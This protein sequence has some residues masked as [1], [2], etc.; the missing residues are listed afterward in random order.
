M[1]NE[2]IERLNEEAAALRVRRDVEYAEY[3]QAGRVKGHVPRE[4]I[5]KLN[6][7]RVSKEIRNKFLSIPDMTSTVSDVLDSFGVDTAIPAYR[8]TAVISGSKICGS[9]FTIR[10]L[11]TQKT[12][13]QYAQEKALVISNKEH[14]ICEDGDV[15]VYDFGGNPDISCIGGN[16]CI[17]CKKNGFAGSVIYGACRDIPV[18]REAGFPV[19]CAGTTQLSGKYR[20]ECMEINGPVNVFGKRCNAGDLI[21]AD[22][23]GICIVPYDMVDQVLA[24]CFK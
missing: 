5:T 7:P 1:V 15:A 18:I 13:G 10:N 24:E 22:E 8:F 9:A 19:F 21:M 12:Y 6:F 3:E 23:S 16:G 20:L 2:I 14:Y 17:L 11:P 4:R